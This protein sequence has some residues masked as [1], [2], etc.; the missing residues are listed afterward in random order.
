MSKKTSLFFNEAGGVSI[1]LLL[2][3][4]GSPLVISGKYIW[5]CVMLALAVALVLNRSMETISDAEKL[6]IRY[7]ILS[8][9][10]LIAELESLEST[11]LPHGSTSSTTD[12]ANTDAA[13]QRRL[14]YL[15]GLS[16][17]TRKYN[18]SDHKRDLALPCQQIAFTTLRLFPEDDEVL[19]GTIS[20]L[21][22]ITKE[23][24][25]RKR[26]KYQAEEFGLDKPILAL[27]NVLARAKEEMD[28][29]REQLL[30]ET[31][32]KG[33]LYLGAVCNDDK[34]LG[35]AAIVV[36]EGGLDLILEAAGWFRFHEDVTN[37]A[38]WAIF[39]LCFDHTRIKAQL[40]RL[41]GIQVICQ[42]MKNNPSN[43][44][45]NRHGVALMFDLL[46]D[47]HDGEGVKWDSW[48]IRKI[49]LGSGLHDVVLAAMTEFS[50]S[51]DIMMM[52]QE[53]LVGTDFRGTIP[54]YQQM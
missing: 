38:L 16:S 10:D 5:G 3:L 48:E 14:R 27:R 53:M 30:A 7:N 43:L 24:Q 51:V 9:D 25:V 40:I 15:E 12:D 49:A 42:S 46:R 44:E 47:N 2:F 18:K 19:A 54:V 52:G 41:G 35:L 17:L 13:V 6:E 21:A 37:W 4:I 29:G 34:K 23:P 20:L 36:E 32:R 39:T 8:P 26:Y 45:V 31:I 28:E 50:D 22:L 11:S 1:P 33:C